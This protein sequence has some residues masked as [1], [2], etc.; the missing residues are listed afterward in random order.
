MAGGIGDRGDLDSGGGR[1]HREHREHREYRG[2]SSRGSSRYRGSAVTSLRHPRYSSLSE[3]RQDMGYD[4]D[5]RSES[6]GEKSDLLKHRQHKD[7]TR[8][9]SEDSRI[10]KQLR[11]LSR[12]DDA[13]RYLTQVQ[14][15]QESIMLSENIKYV[16]RNSDHILDS[17]YESLHAAPSPSCRWEIT[18]CVGRVGHV[19]EADIK[20]FMDLTLERIET[21]RSPE[22]KVLVLRCILEVLQLD[23]PGTQI[24][25]VGVQ[26][27]K[28]LQ[29]VLEVTETPEVMV[30]TVDVL[31][32]LHSSHSTL[33]QPYFQDVVDILVGWHIDHHQPVEVMKYVSMALV[34]FNQLWLSNVSIATTL[35]QQFVE[36]CED[37]VEDIER[38]VAAGALGESASERSMDLNVCA[39]KVAAFINVFTT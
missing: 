35:L 17:L 22:M 8:G 23:K 13:E 34:S 20:R 12:E 3:R 10:S 1:G 21:W 14:Q 38:E 7:M 27:V 2:G 29:G 6:L 36:D 33:L 37:Y 19:M 39:K 18:R 26:V 25:V 15:L 24:S 5:L 16:R 31:R 30:A 32:C 9:F 4:D 28:G 11:R